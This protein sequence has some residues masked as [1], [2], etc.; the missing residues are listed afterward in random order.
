[1]SDP[2]FEE[3]L[4]ALRAD[5]H[6]NYRLASG[7]LTGGNGGT[8]SDFMASWYDDVGDEPWANGAWCAGCRMAVPCRRP[9]GDDPEIGVTYDRPEP[10][11]ENC[12]D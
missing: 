8:W 9:C 12:E 10:L 2:D 4:A 1:M 5:I 6:D 11:E 7:R 3:R